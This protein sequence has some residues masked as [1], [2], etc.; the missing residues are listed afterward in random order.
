MDGTSIKVGMR[1]LLV[2]GQGTICERCFLFLF[3][4][5]KSVYTYAYWD[6]LHPDF[7]SSFSLSSHRLKLLHGCLRY[8]MSYAWALHSGGG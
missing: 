1:F 2:L 7:L 8:G 4:I 5:K 3:L 6:A